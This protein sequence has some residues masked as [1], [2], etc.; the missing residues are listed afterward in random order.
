MIE[1]EITEESIDIGECYHKILD[2]SCGG[3]DLFVGTVRDLTENRKVVRLEYEAYKSMAEK[4][5]NKIVTESLKQW[6]VKNIIVKHRI[7]IL[8]PMDIAVLIGVAAGH[9]DE[10]F[11]ACRYIIDTLKQTV[12]IWKKEVFIDGETWVSNH[13]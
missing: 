6:P 10:A 12:P 1:I 4:E 7:G 11:K 9:R 13:P 8:K 2:A 3:I 5:L